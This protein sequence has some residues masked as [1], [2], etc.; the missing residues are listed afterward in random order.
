MPA[1]TL[2]GAVIYQGAG[3]L[4][5]GTMAA[6]VGSSGYLGRKFGSWI[7]EGGGKLLNYIFEDCTESISDEWGD[8]L[9]NAEQELWGGVLGCQPPRRRASHAVE[10]VILRCSIAR[11]TSQIRLLATLGLVGSSSPATDARA[12]VSRGVIGLVLTGVGHTGAVT[13]ACA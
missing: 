11:K 10:G 2:E 8:I 12:G 3:A 9:F 6:G 4:G 7:D 1:N 13:A 5:I